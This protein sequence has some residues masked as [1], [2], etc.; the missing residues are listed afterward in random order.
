MEDMERIKVADTNL[1]LKTKYRLPSSESLLLGHNFN[2]VKMV[3]FVHQKFLI[4][5]SIPVFDCTITFWN[6]N[7]AHTN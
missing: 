4:P 1:T 6:L 3:I 2:E 5:T 7:H